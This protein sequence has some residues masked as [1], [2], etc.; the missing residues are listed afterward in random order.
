M[1]NQKSLPKVSAPLSRHLLFLALPPLTSFTH[2][3]FIMD[4]RWIPP[5]KPT[6]TVLC[7]SENAQTRPTY[8]D[9]LYRNQRGPRLLA[10]FDREPVYK[11]WHAICHIVKRDVCSKGQHCDRGSTGTCYFYHH[12]GCFDHEEFLLGN[13]T[14]V[15]KPFVVECKLES[16][17]SSHPSRRE[18]QMLS[19]DVSMA[20]RTD[21]TGLYKYRYLP[22]ILVHEGGTRDELTIDSRFDGLCSRNSLQMSLI[23]L[24][25]HT[26]SP[27]LNHACRDPYL[28]STDKSKMMSLTSKSKSSVRVVSG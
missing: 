18:R 22:P 8:V 9:D 21:G 28:Y 24:S 7:K 27:C 12:N 10:M 4:C 15:P 16:P 2:Q 6:A 19:F 5:Q 20:L 26:T 11:T 23:D 3:S 17:P 1:Q 14:F 25:L 13:D